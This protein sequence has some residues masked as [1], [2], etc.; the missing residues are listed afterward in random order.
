MER[1]V[2]ASTTIGLVYGRV[3]RGPARRSGCD[4]PRDPGERRQSRPAAGTELSID[5]GAGASVNQQ[6]TV[7][8]GAPRSTGNG[9]VMPLSWEATGRFAWLPAFDGEL[10][11]GPASGG[12]NV[13]LRGTYTVPLGVLG[14]V[15]DT[16]AGGRIARRSL[17]GLVERLAARLEREAEQTS[18]SWIDYHEPL[19]AESPREC[20][21]RSTSADRENALGLRPQSRGLVLAGL[22]T[23][24]SAAPSASTS[25]GSARRAVSSSW[26]AA[27]P[28]TTRGWTHRARARRR[29]LS[30]RARCPLG[31]RHSACQRACRRRS[32]A[33][34]SDAGTGDG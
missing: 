23:R 16:V 17:A 33:R 26:I 20:A 2:E 27:S 30:C 28:F 24:R 4:V 10:D 7:H 31:R 32:P 9:L 14:R 21:R 34:R 3:A 15:G 18:A 12:A 19:A 6:I 25:S 29:A 22:T 8:L 11:V 1:S 13:R 5:L